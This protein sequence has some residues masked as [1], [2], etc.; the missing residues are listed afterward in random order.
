M[1]KLFKKK[2]KYYTHEQSTTIVLLDKLL[3]NDKINECEYDKIFNIIDK[4]SKYEYIK[5]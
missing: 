4:L 1:L 3:R 2:I 5:K